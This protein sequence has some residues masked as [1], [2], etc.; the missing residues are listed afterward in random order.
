[1]TLLYTPLQKRYSQPFLSNPNYFI[2]TPF[3]KLL[4]EYYVFNC[5]L[6]IWT[7]TQPLHSLYT[8][9]TQPF[10]NPWL[11][12]NTLDHILSSLFYQPGVGP[13]LDRNQQH[14]INLFDFLLHS[15]AIQH[16]HARKKNL[17]NGEILMTDCT[18]LSLT[19]VRM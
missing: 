10:H 17:S 2:K 14:R 16:S 6:R 4:V 3:C 12:D 15:F 8:A 9:F 13:L 7:R 18:N 19:L 11:C 1:M 5:K